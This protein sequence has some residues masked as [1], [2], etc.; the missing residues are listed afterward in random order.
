MF[1]H[2][3]R[4]ASRLGVIVAMAA[5][6][7]GCTAAALMAGGGGSDKSAITLAQSSYGAADMLS[8]Q[9]QAIM[10]RDVPL[11]IG[12][13]GDIAH[14]SAVTPF[15]QT[16]GS[17]MAARFVQ[18]GYN[19]SASTY[20]EMS[21]GAPPPTIMPPMGQNMYGN[22]YGG[23]GAANTVSS[24]MLT[25]QYAVARDDVMVNLRLLDTTSNRVLAAYDYTVPLT[26]D[27]EELTTVP[28]TQK[29][30]FGF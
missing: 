7:S 1:M 18:L 6:L 10:T 14:P 23:G 5:L 3:A 27:V 20:S 21:G 11:Q 12:M 26:R 13:I 8:Q 28:G 15:G 24:A 17:Q 4:H 25:G 2:A 19:V 30:L 29:N 16:I 22:A 9:T